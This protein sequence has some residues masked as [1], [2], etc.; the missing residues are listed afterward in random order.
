LSGVLSIEIAI[1]KTHK[2]ASRDSGDTAE[3]VERPTG[4]LSVVLVDGQGSGAAAKSLSMMVSSK[5]VGLLKEGVRDGVVARG[6]HDFLHA[7]RHG[8]VSATLDIVSVDLA[9]ST[10]VVT[11]NSPVP[12]LVRS[13]DGIILH[14]SSSRP[15][16]LYRHTRP[17]IEQFPL[18]EGLAIIVFSDGI[19]TAGDRAHKRIDLM[20]WASQA[21]TCE[22]EAHDI[23]DGLLAA[24]IAA[25]DGRPGDDMTVVATTITA[26]DQ[27]QPVRTL[28]VS[29]PFPG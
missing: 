17:S 2:Y 22:V 25:A 10:V 15:I 29:L 16:G 24:A 4:G 23:A 18:E 3:T 12:F 19:H 27:V 11:R 14:T 20:E 26:T 21:L 7:Y 5:A 28:R 9:T 1:A 6:T 8:K 13:K